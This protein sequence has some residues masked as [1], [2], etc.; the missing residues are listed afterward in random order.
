MESGL[1][2]QNPITNFQLPKDRFKRS[3]LSCGQ[4]VFTGHSGFILLIGSS[5]AFFGVIVA[6]VAGRDLGR[7]TV[8]ILFT[9]GHELHLLK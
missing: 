2:F 7:I 6:R 8:D 4:G 1:F 3:F 9:C 5:V